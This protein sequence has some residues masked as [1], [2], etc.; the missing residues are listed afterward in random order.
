[1]VSEK[2]CPIGSLRNF[3]GVKIFYKSAARINVATMLEQYTCRRSCVLICMR[4]HNTHCIGHKVAK[5]AY[6]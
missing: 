4:L 3:S 2:Y 1:M 6:L 5:L